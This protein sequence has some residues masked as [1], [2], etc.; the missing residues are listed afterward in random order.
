MMY[1]INSIKLIKPANKK[2]REFSEYI[3]NYEH[4]L[5]KDE[6]SL[7]ALSVD[8]ERKV[9][10]LNGKYNNSADLVVRKFGNNLQQAVKAL[11]KEESLALMSIV[12]IKGAYE[13]SE[14]YKTI[15]IE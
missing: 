3:Q 14:K 4:I 9:C 6:C 2:Q 15:K 11:N 13:F 5:I 12:I 1:F 7:D 8:I 10:E